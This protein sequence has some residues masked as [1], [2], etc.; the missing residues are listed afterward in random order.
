MKY[1]VGPSG[2]GDNYNKGSTSS[3]SCLISEYFFCVRG[4][5]PGVSNY[6]P[7]VPGSRSCYGDRVSG[8]F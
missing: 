4:G 8:V 2:G 6:V 3:F 5:V 1:R 7:Q